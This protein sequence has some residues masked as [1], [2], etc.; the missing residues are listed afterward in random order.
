MLAMWK[1]HQ[2]L[3][4]AEAAAYQALVRIGQAR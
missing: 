2:P 1:Q 4:A 3:R